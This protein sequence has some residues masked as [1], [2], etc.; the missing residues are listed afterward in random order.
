MK[1]TA[2]AGLFVCA[3]ML[4]SPVF[5]ADDLCQINLVKI[6]DAQA[7]LLATSENTKDDIDAMVEKAKAE[8]AAGKKE[9]CIST[10]TQAL[11]KLQNLTKGDDNK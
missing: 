2:L 10:T 7:T 3:T 1:R 9:D 4:A 8:Q 6:A 11:Q 5:A